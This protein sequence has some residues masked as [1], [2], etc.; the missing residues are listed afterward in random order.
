MDGLAALTGRGK[1]PTRLRRRRQRAAD[2]AW[3]SPRGRRRPRPRGDPDGRRV[4]IPFLGPAGSGA[5]ISGAGRRGVRGDHRA[6]VPQRD[7]RPG[8]RPDRLQPTGP[9]RRRRRVPDAA[10][11]RRVRRDRAVG[12]GATRSLAGSAT[13]AEVVSYDCGHFAIY[14]GA[15]FERS[16][17]RQVEFLR[18][19]TRTQHDARI[20]TRSV[21]WSVSE[22]SRS[23][24]DAGRA[25]S[26]PVGKSSSWTASVGVV[27]VVLG[28]VDDVHA[29]NLENRRCPQRP[30]HGNSRST[31]H[32]ACVTFPSPQ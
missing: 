24:L 1:R 5:M 17:A 20:R 3:A 15:E 14:A 28:L 30:R 2:R 31:S 11:D 27:D 4:M 21:G 29:S 10:G 12:R 19:R 8:H 16:I 18:A 23:E 9:P 32:V 6:D 7:V 22:A 26:I 25:A 13:A